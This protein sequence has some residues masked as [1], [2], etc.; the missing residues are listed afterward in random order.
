MRYGEGAAKAN[1]F[2]QDMKSISNSET[3]A[4][5]KVRLKLWWGSILGDKT[6]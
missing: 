1:H 2:L 3:K 4:N 5:L 6:I